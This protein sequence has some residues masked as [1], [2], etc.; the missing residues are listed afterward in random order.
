M[1]YIT[2]RKEAFYYIAEPVGEV[3]FDLYNFSSMS[4]TEEAVQT[5]INWNIGLLRLTG[6]RVNV[7]YNLV[8]DFLTI[9]ETL[10]TSSVTEKLLQ[11]FSDKGFNSNYNNEIPFRLTIRNLKIE[12]VLSTIQDNTFQSLNN[13]VSSLNC[14][15]WRLL[16]QK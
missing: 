3:F 11:Y 13:T 7:E 15:T 5:I 1:I 6:V 2:E 8:L 12:D 10:H 16:I 9:T 14:S 4:R